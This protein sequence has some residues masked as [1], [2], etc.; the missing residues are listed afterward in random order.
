[1]LKENQIVEIKWNGQTKKYWEDKGYKYTKAGEKFN[2]FAH[3]LPSKSSVFVDVICD[4]CGT[5]F[6][7]RMYSYTACSSSGK[8]AC[9]K[10]KAEKAKEF[11]LKNYGVKNVMQREEVRDKFKNTLLTKYGVDSPLKNKEFLEKALKNTNQNEK[12]EKT[13]KTCLLKYGVDNPAKNKEIA[14]KAKNTCLKKYG[15]F[16]SQCDKEIRQ[17]SFQ[18]MLNNGNVPSSKP[19]RQMVDKIKSLYGEENC[20]PQ[21]V[22]DKV[23]FDCLLQINDTKIDIEYDCDYWHDR[24][25]D[26]CRDYFSMK[27]GFKV[28]RFRTNNSIPTENQIKCAIN[29]LLYS[30][31]RILIIDI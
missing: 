8:I 20:F 27:N 13:K 21:Y 2:V 7:M 26:E 15:G 25:R 1:M 18:T 28:L 24:K 10:C 9:C 12:V 4:Y 23:I 17:K 19:E 16:S 6:K 29:D 14:Q 31:K 5:D 11:N 3:E 30:N 22:Y